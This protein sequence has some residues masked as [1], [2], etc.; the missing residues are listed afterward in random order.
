MP[1]Q[2][3]KEIL[4]YILMVYPSTKLD[5]ANVHIVLLSHQK[6]KNSAIGTFAVI[7]GNPLK[8]VSTIII[9][10]TEKIMMI[11][12]FGKQHI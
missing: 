10:M 1:L 2:Y 8:M 5:I 3:R 7:A 12:I 6:L 11:L 9:I 4:C